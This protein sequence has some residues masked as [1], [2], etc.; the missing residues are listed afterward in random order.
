MK[1]TLYSIDIVYR[2]IRS[3]YVKRF[4]YNT[5]PNSANVVNDELARLHSSAR[6]VTGSATNITTFENPNPSEA[7]NDFGYNPGFV[8]EEYLS[9]GPSMNYLL[10]DIREMREWLF[11]A[12]YLYKDGKGHIATE[13]LLRTGTLTS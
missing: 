6:I 5:E 10:E 11:R 7:A 3:Y 2:I 1:N 13:T 12:G 8:L 9:D 4:P